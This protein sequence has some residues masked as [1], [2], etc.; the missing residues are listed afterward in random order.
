MKVMQEILEGKIKKQINK[1]TKY[2][3]NK[4]TTVIEEKCTLLFADRRQVLKNITPAKYQ[5][6][7]DDPSIFKREKSQKSNSKYYESTPKAK[8]T[9]Y[10]APLAINTSA[11]RKRSQ[12][13]SHKSSSSRQKSKSNYNSVQNIAKV[14]T[15]DYDT[16]LETDSIPSL[17][18]IPPVAA[19]KPPVT[20]K[21]NKTQQM[22]KKLSI[23]MSKKHDFSCIPSHQTKLGETI[24]IQTGRLGVS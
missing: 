8:P 17:K 11:V 19:P 7:N 18:V 3:D 9:S 1:L 23:G 13:K 24:N 5:N 2:Y 4:F 16:N 10:D 14:A 21:L 15:L 22:M 20:P 12:H 6:T